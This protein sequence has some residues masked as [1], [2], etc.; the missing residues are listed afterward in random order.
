MLMFSYFWPFLKTCISTIAFPFLLYQ[1]IQWV[2]HREMLVI[3][4]PWNSSSPIQLL[5][6]LVWLSKL[7][8]HLDRTCEITTAPPT[9][10]PKPSLLTSVVLLQLRSVE[11]VQ[12]NGALSRLWTSLSQQRH[13]S[14]GHRQH[15]RDRRQETW[16]FLRSLWENVKNVFYMTPQ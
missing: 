15:G 14:P 5:H 16:S 2:T 3:F 13:T 8:Q 12:T 4:Q 1:W 7:Q 10:S 6:N 9:K 11:A